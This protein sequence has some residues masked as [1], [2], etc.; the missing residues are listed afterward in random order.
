[1]KTANVR[2]SLRPRRL[3]PALG[4]CLFGT[5]IA[6]AEGPTPSS[7]PVMEGPRL[8]FPSP[9]GF[10]IGPVDVT[11]L[12]DGSLIAVWV[13]RETGGSPRSW[14]MQKF[15][16]SGQPI[17]PERTVAEDDADGGDLASAD[18][19]D[20]A[21]VWSTG[22][23]DSDIKAQRFLSTGDPNGAELLV[24]TYT[25]GEQ[26]GLSVDMTPDGSFIVT[27]VDRSP[28]GF[29][30]VR[31][32]R[33]DSA[34]SP[35][36]DEFPVQQSTT[37]FKNDS[38]VALLPEGDF[39][40]VWPSGGF[41]LHGGIFD[42]AGAPL[43]GDFQVSDPHPN[44]PYRHIDPALLVQ[45]NGDFVVAWSADYAFY[46][47]YL[48]YRR[49]TSVGTPLPT[50]PDFRTAV[51]SN[52]F[53]QQ[54]PSL[55]HAPTTA[56]SW[57]GLTTISWAGPHASKAGSSIRTAPW[58]TSSPSTRVPAMKWSHVSRARARTSWSCGRKISTTA[59]RLPND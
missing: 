16:P 1:M 5:L 30:R 24:N 13:R 39:V 49:F 20:F 29:D 33:Y 22:G 23:D 47:A 41:V 28:A 38:A 42:S 14:R 21:L 32:R 4:L 44:F 18:T 34:G 10:G 17:G 52:Y 26:T 35:L 56:S 46:G 31:G 36:D 8:H 19:G 2:A 6:V 27:W 50:G 3:L 58:P 37:G 59:I 40:A 54:T 25:T 57:L 51:G 12:P 43:T 53:W 11:M 7:S 55:A 45:S 15:S 9:Y 48:N